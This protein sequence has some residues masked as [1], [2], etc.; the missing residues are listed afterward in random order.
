[1]DVLFLTLK[2]VETSSSS[3]L[4]TMNSRGG[5]CCLTPATIAGQWLTPSM[6][7]MSTSGSVSPCTLSLVAMSSSVSPC[8]L[9]LVAMSSRVGRRSTACSKPP[10]RPG[11]SPPPPWW[12]KLGTFV[13]PSYT[14]PL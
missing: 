5:C 13:P 6:F 10:Y 11:P 12:R 3:M 8:T 9:S 2:M 7:L 4:Y 1:M 14:L